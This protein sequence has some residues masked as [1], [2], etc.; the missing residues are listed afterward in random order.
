MPANVPTWWT[1]DRVDATVNREYVYSHLRADEQEL[2]KQSPSFADGLT[3]DTYLDWI[4][5]KARRFFLTLVDSGVPDQIF[6][7]VDDSYDDGDL[8]IDEES[9]PDLHLSYEPSPALNKRF[10]KAQYRYLL[11]VLEDGEHIRYAEEETVPVYASGLKATI[12]SL[13][14]DGVDKVRLSASTSRYFVRKKINVD[15]RPNGTSEAL[16]LG[17]IASLR[18]Y[19]HPHLSSIFASYLQQDSIYVLFTPAP[20]YSLKSF[21]SDVPKAFDHLAK[22]QRRQKLLSWTHC[23]AGAL[24]WLHTNGRPHG[25]IRPSNIQV[26]DDN[27]HIYLGQFDDPGV[28]GTHTKVDDL[29]SYQYAAPVSILPFNSCQGCSTVVHLLV[30]DTSPI[31]RAFAP[32][33]ISADVHL[34]DHIGTMEESSDN[35]NYSTIQG[36]GKF[37]WSHSKTCQA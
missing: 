1:D 31:I 16:V 9:I 29:E 32:T 26:T 13:G 18:R 28:L 34:H 5:T 30:I 35:A 33:Q 20:A 19:A 14:K 7:I 36:H 12:L 2:L 22:S 8:P 11:R 3:D 23:L 24:R 6:G 17:E 10:Y 25:A 4:L 15:H 37:W 27:F 21:L